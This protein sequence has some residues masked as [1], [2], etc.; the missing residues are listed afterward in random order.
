[1]EKIA[2]SD[3]YSVGI[4][5]LD[6]QHQ[7]IVDVI[8]RLIQEAKV[9]VG[10]ETISILL[11]RLTAYADEHFRMEEQ[12]LQKHEYP[13][14]SEQKNEHLEYR[15]KIA[16]FCLETINHDESVPRDLLRYIRDW[17]NLHILELDMDFKTYLNGRGVF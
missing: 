4:E 1:M 6:R 17:W 8:N 5:L 13:G 10:S 2:W 15:K 12:L 7:Q 16:H 3:D 11:T 14:L 9:D